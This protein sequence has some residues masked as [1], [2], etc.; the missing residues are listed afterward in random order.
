MADELRALRAR[1]RSL[2]SDN[3][4]LRAAYNEAV[5]ELLQLKNAVS[6]APE[7]LRR[8]Q[9]TP[10]PSTA[11]PA[12]EPPARPRKWWQSAGR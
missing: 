3:Q 6:P 12:A 9:Q 4:Q 2:E 10:H 7:G 8:L 1:V 5:D 11:Q